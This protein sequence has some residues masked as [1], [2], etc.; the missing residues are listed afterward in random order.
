MTPWNR[1]A[2]DQDY[3]AAILDLAMKCEPPL[4]HYFLDGRHRCQC[5]A[6]DD[7]DVKEVER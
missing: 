1:D 5:G 6:L 3:I 7:R 2:T 4:I